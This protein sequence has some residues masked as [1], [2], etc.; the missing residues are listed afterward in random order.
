M[1]APTHIRR[2]VMP[3]VR[4]LDHSGAVREVPPEPRVVRTNQRSLVAASLIACP[5]RAGRG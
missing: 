2:F 3:T 5:G 4:E 1:N